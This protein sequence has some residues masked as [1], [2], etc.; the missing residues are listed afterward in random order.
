MP[1]SRVDR[2]AAELGV[3]H[4][5]AGERHV[6][7]PAARRV[8]DRSP[9]GDGIARVGRDDGRRR[10]RATSSSSAAR[11]L[12]SSPTTQR[13]RPPVR[14]ASAAQ[15]M[16]LLPPA[17]RITTRAARPHE[18]RHLRGGA[19]DVE[20]GQGESLGQVVREL[21]VRAAREEDGLALDVDLGARRA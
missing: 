5:D 1:R 20:R 8:E 2:M 4:V 3:G 14:R 9:D 10:G 12:A 18:A 13:P 11:V 21:G 16:P 17:P 7:L 19:G 6:G 15:R